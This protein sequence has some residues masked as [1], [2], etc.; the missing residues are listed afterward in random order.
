MIKI[1]THKVK[2]PF[3]KYVNLGIPKIYIYIYVTPFQY[4][5][6]LKDNM[7]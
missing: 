6:F 1:L 5:T 3:E 7:L 4:K 2:D